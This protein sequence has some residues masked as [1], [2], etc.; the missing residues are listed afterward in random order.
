MASAAR[1]FYILHAGTAHKSKWL[2]VQSM[3]GQTG[4]FAGQIDRRQIIQVFR[5]IP[6]LPVNLNKYGSKTT[7]EHYGTAIAIVSAGGNPLKFRKL[8]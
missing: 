7:F 2:P 5:L 8:N 1:F 4:T 3:Y 6:A